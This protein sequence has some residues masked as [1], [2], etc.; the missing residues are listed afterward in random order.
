MLC[1]PD[2]FRHALNRRVDKKVR[3]YALYVNIEVDPLPLARVNCSYFC[4]HN[5]ENLP[6]IVPFCYLPLVLQLVTF[7]L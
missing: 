1:W 7:Y 3:V 5:T 6:F 2:I 4:D